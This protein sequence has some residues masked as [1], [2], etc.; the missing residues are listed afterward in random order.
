M[1]GKKL[2]LL[3][4]CSTLSTLAMGSEWNRTELSLEN[5]QRLNTPSNRSKGQNW[6]NFGLT[7]DFKRSIVEGKFDGDIRMS[8][9]DG[10][11]MTSISEGY[12][13]YKGTENDIALG[14]KKLNWNPN[15]Q[16]WMLG[17]IN[18]VRGF[19]LLD[20]KE[21][22]LIGLH[23][24]NPAGP[25]KTEVFLSYF[26]VP[27]LSPGIKIENG[28]VSSPSEWVKLPPKRT[29]LSGQD[30]DVYYKLDKP[31]VRDV[32]INKSLGL[33]MEYSWKRGRLAGYSLYKPENKLR[34]NAEAYYDPNIGA[35]AV[36][37]DPVVNHH[38]IY[39]SFVQ[40]Q[41]NNVN[42]IAGF[43]V[44]DPNANLG[45]D[46]DNLSG[47]LD[48]N[49]NGKTFSSDYFVIEPKYEREAF[50]H[51]SMSSTWDYGTFA[52][53]YL[54]YISEHN[55][56]S[57]DFYSDTV[58]WKQAIGLEGTYNFTDDLEG[59]GAIRYDLK[60]CDNILQSEIAYKL[61]GRLRLGLGIEFLRSP[62]I[63]SYWSAYR[64]ND[65]FYT[66]VQYNF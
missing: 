25:L 30:V 46:F 27:T 31:N 42:L 12:F 35:V 15:E 55:K 59:L 7:Y 1:K 16:F 14:R 40:Q 50:G 41:V 56:G 38:A 10:Q 43:Q 65:I 13:R 23:Y 3:S 62:E 53:H 54:H 47:K 60:R 37:A 33:N 9:E 66:S 32:V 21:E 22:G 8:I 61:M 17:H 24:V 48:E 64:T 28:Q 2:V 5:F 45:S 36:N 11:T 63:T 19:R 51:A 6:G 57:D 4:I 20:S 58:K 39:G 52:I 49:A 26:Y 29:V 34:I 18:G 44:V